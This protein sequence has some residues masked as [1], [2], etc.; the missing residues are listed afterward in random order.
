MPEFLTIRVYAP[1]CSYDSCVPLAA[2]ERSAV[3]IGNSLLGYYGG[4]PKANMLKLCNIIY[5]V[6][7]PRIVGE[8]TEKIRQNINKSRRV[9]PAQ[10]VLLACSEKRRPFQKA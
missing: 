9:K 8:F 3:K 2:G 5:F 10:R 7:N 4:T 1:N 6:Y